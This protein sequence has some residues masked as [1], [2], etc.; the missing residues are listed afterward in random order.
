SGERRRGMRAD[1][2]VARRDQPTLPVRMTPSGPS[3]ASMTTLRTRDSLLGAWPFQAIRTKFG[4][5]KVYSMVLILETRSHLP[6]LCD[7]LDIGS[8]AGKVIV[9]DGAKCRRQDIKAGMLET[10]GGTVRIEPGRHGR[11]AAILR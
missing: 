9:A 11:I 4:L 2:A 1:L 5:L 7:I 3:G 6:R 8:N 10:H